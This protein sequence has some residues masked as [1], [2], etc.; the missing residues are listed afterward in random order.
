MQLSGGQIAGIVIGV[1]GAVTLII[2]ISIIA[3]AV[4]KNPSYLGTI[5]SK[6]GGNSTAFTSSKHAN[7]HGSKTIEGDVHRKITKTALCKCSIM[8]SQLQAE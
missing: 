5:L 4:H 3:V 8:G 6:I 7:P 1:G 2:L